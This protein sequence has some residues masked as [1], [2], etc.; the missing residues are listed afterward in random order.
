MACPGDDDRILE[1][2]RVG[3]YVG[4]RIQPRQ[5]IRLDGIGE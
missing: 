5:P 4:L 1:Q 3:E 2:G